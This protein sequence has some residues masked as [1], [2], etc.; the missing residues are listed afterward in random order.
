MNFGWLVASIDG[1]TDHPSRTT[2]RSRVRTGITWSLSA[3]ALVA[4]MIAGWIRY[5]FGDVGLEAIVTNLPIGGRAVGNESLATE[6]VLVCLG[7]PLLLLVGTAVALHLWRRRVPAARSE[8]TSRRRLR[9]VLS[10]TAFIGSVSV[11]LTVTGVPQ[12]AVA[13]LTGQ[14][15]APYYVDPKVTSAPTKPKNLVTIYLESMENTFRDTDIF[16]ENLLANLD[17]A[18]QDYAAYDGL[19]Q[20]PGG[21]WTMAGLVATQCG[22][23]LKSEV[24]VPGAHPNISAQDVDEYLPGATCLGDILADAGYTSA[25]LGGA[26][27]EFAGKNT[28]L[29]DHGYSQ[30]TGRNEW[31]KAGKDPAEMSIWGLSDN[32]LFQEARSKVDAL[33]AQD[34]PFHL[35]MLTLD[36]H[37]PAGIFPSCNTDNAVAMATAIKCST[38]AAAGFIK[39]LESSGYLDDTVVVIMGDHLKGT[40]GASDYK[41]EMAQA[42][43]RTILLEIASP[44]PIRYNR[45][46]ADQFSMLPTTLEL[47]DFKIPGGQAGLGVSLIG[48]HDITDTAADLPPKE[49]GELVGSPSVELYQKFWRGTE[50]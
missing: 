7:I 25:W 33:H 10:V 47:L 2:A 27:D 46:S 40:S 15:I 12:H 28:F 9:V 18:T 8:R 49:Y 42:D 23:P 17:S 1:M 36:T 21:G 39:Y 37:E 38:K 16:G 35:T 14:S 6:A 41:T 3:L 34:E 13:V 22:I 29:S 50:H 44:D 31:L 30:I 24:L 11:L 4:L 5:R 48:Q 45:S 32:M 19:Q 20:Y 26:D 43:S